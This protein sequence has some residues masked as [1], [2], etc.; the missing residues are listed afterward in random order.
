MSHRDG[1]DDRKTETRATLVPGAGRVETHEALEYTL[2]LTRR[3]TGAIVADSEQRR[4]TVS[5]KRHPYLP[6]CVTGRFVEKVPQQ[7][8]QSLGITDDAGGL[9]TGRIDRDSEPRCG[10]AG[11]LSHQ[12]VEIDL[13]RLQSEP[14]LIGPSQ[15][16]QVGYQ[17]LQSK[18]LRQQVSRQLFE[19]Y[20]PRTRVS[21]LEHR[22]DRGNRAL[23][24]VRGV[25]HEASLALCRGFDAIEHPVH[26][27]G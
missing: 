17:A 22:S 5:L 26:R 11:L 3:D 1:A 24:L 18:I 7:P 20:A 4:P 6:G 14:V 15:D 2:L 8:P 9:D 12:I 25:G 13:H 27:P 23:Q 21:D 19:R 10:S 16:Q